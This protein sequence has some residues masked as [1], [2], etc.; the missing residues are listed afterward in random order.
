[1]LSVES[2]RSNDD[3]LVVELNEMDDDWLVEDDS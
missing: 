2:K 1:M 3:E